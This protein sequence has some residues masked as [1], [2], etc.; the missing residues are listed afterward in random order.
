[1]AQTPH[2]YLYDT[3][4]WQRRR[5]H[6]LL[7]EPLCAFCLERDIVTPATV[8][9]HV[10]P[11]RG[12]INKF[13]LGKL[14]SLCMPCH[15]RVKQQAE[16]RGFIKGSDAS[17]RPL[18]PSHWANRPCGRAHRKPAGELGFPVTGRSGPT[19]L[20]HRRAAV[21]VASR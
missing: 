17:G 5:A 1:M 15:N 13:R 19:R 16:H 7:V 18:D 8:A 10:E 4:A 11:H 21:R 6:Q 14:Q 3:A 2:K 20:T 9:D 12:D